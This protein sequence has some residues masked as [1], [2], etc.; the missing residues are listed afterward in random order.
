MTAQSASS[1]IG[2]SLTDESTPPRSFCLSW[3]HYVF[4]LGVKNSD[5]RS[6]YEI[7]SVAQDWTVRE[8]KRQF[9]TSLYER[10]EITLPK[11]TNIHAKEY[12]LYLPAGVLAAVVEVDRR[13]GA[14]G[15]RQPRRDARVDSIEAAG[16][17]DKIGDRRIDRAEKA[18][19]HAER[20][21]LRVGI[22]GG[23][24]GLPAAAVV[25]MAKACQSVYLS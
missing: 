2:E 12:Q 24:V 13:P 18:P 8:L 6:F 21:A 3:T 10:L 9:D 7:E 19:I 5:E 4:L 16:T 22:A 1:Q 25:A 17:Q 11:D 23:P 15:H 14:T 20:L